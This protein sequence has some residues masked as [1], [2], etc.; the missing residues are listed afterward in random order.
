[1]GITKKIST[2]YVLAAG[3]CIPILWAF[4]LSSG[5]FGRI[6]TEP[7]FASFVLCADFSAA[8]LALTS[9]IGT[10]AKRAWADR[11]RPAA[12]GM[13]FYAAIIASGE[14]LQIRQPLFCAVFL[15]LTVFTAAVIVLNA[16]GSA[17]NP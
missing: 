14:F 16:A 2:I 9:G 8:A 17:V 13:V 15:I 3:I 12:I 5:M 11:L 6:R 4:L 10:L 1:M 7:V